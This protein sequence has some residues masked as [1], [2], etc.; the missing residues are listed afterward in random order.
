MTKRT[1]NIVVGIPLLIVFFYTIMYSF[2][3]VLIFHPSKIE[4]NHEFVFD[5]EFEA[6]RK[7]P[8]CQLVVNWVSS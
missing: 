2:Q 6:I 1:R 8:V 4:M 7:Q 5:H 3:E